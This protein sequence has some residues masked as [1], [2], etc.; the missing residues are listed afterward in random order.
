MR[1]DT[2]SLIAAQSAPR[3]AQAPRLSPQGAQ[4]ADNPLFEPLV[5]REVKAEPAPAKPLAAAPQTP[6]RR[7]GAVLDITV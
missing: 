4:P 1:I 5:F 6:P 3:P 2:S 7:P